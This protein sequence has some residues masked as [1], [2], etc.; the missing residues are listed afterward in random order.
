MRVIE[1]KVRTGGGPWLGLALA[2]TQALANTSRD[3]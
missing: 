1:G 3:A 2:L